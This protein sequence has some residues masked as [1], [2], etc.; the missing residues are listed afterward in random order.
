MTAVD[1]PLPRKDKGTATNLE[2]DTLRKLVLGAEYEQALKSI[3]SEDD[4]ERISRV[5][6]EAIYHRNQHDNSMI[7]AISPILDEAL[8]RVIQH[9]PEKITSSVYPIIGPSIRKAVASAFSDMMQTLNHVLESSF[10]VKAWFWRFHAWRLGMTYSEFVLLKTL[11]F[12]VDQV[13]L[14]HRETGIL[15]NTVY[16]QDSGAENPE[17][18]SSMLVAINDFVA[19]SFDSSTDGVVDS[20]RVGDFYLEIDA[21]PHA[22]LAAVVRGSQLNKV[23]GLLKPKLER[24]HLVFGQKLI[25]FKGVCSD[26][27]GTTGLLESCLTEQSLHDEKKKAPWMAWCFVAVL[28]SA[29]GWKG[30]QYYQINNQYLN[31][32]NNLKSESGYIVINEKKNFPDLN[33]DVLRSPLSIDPRQWLLLQ[34]TGKWHVYIESQQSPLDIKKYLLKFMPVLY[35]LNSDIQY[36]VKNDILYFKGKIYLEQYKALEQDVLLSSVFSGVNLSNVNVVSGLDKKALLIKEWETIQ[37]KIDSVNFRFQPNSALL[38]SG[39]NKKF[40]T[41]IEDIRKIIQ[42]AN[43]ISIKNWQIYITGYADPSGSAD[44]NLNISEKRAKLV[45]SILQENNIPDKF[46]LAWGVGNLEGS[47]LTEED[48]RMVSIQLVHSDFPGKELNDN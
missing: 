11:S 31:I 17:L 45:K 29:I 4:L 38:K 1:L 16:A 46:L 23:H 27:D 9:H 25:K 47:N 3:T 22:I 10:S 5:I 43:I 20:I 41:F 37:S 24:I 36:N 33:V 21:G 18:V 44:T 39:E 8:H 42:L 30:Y 19:D 7:D 48:Q 13:L 34:D 14:I 26:F 2:L 15:L 32:I 28:L 40:S 12:K 6:T 35:S